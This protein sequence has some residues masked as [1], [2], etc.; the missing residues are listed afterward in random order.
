[1]SPL[2]RQEPVPR[3]H[4]PAARACRPPAAAA[5]AH[6]GPAAPAAGTP[7]TT[8][9]SAAAG[10]RSARPPRRGCFREPMMRTLP[11]TRRRS[12]PS[13]SRGP[14]CCHSP[15][16]SRPHRASAPRACLRS[17]S[18]AA[19]LPVA[20]WPRRPCAPAELPGL[21]LPPPTSGG[22]SA[23]DPSCCGRIPRTA[24]S[25]RPR[26]RPRVRPTASLRPHRAG[27]LRRG[28][29]HMPGGIPRARMRRRAV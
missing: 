10:S 25:S 4:S 15:T 13:A 23:G 20:T 7:V 19:S 16:S 27:L 17:R 26:P 21:R 14:R 9:A 5:A 12:S 22:W 8:S 24:A 2:M 11:L 18:T 6:R 3:A 28:P 1:M 29:P